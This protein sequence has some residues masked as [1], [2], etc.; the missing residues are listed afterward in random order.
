[1]LQV[2]C[3]DG[4]TVMLRGSDSMVV[5][6][7]PESDTGP[8]DE[9]DG[10]TASDAFDAAPI[11][12]VVDATTEDDAAGDAESMDSDAGGCGCV[13]E[14]EPVCGADGRSYESACEATCAGVEI[15]PESRC[16]GDGC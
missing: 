1:M 9:L 5:D 4:G 2:A 8:S 7:A 12:A 3:Q 13:P 10:T 11:D 14:A 15:D 16:D 6:A